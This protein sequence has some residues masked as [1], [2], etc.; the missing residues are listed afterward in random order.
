MRC[1]FKQTCGKNLEFHAAGGS[2]SGKFVLR[3]RSD[4]KGDGHGWPP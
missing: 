4:I 1:F 2:L 3:L